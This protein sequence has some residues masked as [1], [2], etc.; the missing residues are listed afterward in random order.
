MQLGI[1]K[2]I[3]EE[4]KSFV[5]HQKKIMSEALIRQEA[6][7][8]TLTRS[9]K[10]RLEKNID[11]KGFGIVAEIKRASPYYGINVKKLF[12]AELA[13]IYQK[14]GASC[15]GVHTDQSFFKGKNQDLI[16]VRNSS[17]LPILRKDFIISKYQIYET[18]YLGADAILLTVALLEQAKL[19]EYS[20]LARE[21]G[22]DIVLEVNSTEDVDRAMKLPNKIICI[23][24][25]NLTSFKTDLKKSFELAKYIG[26]DE[27]KMLE[28]GI[29]NKEEIATLK[30]NHINSCILGGTLINSEN[31][32]ATIHKI[33]FS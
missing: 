28:G 4:K 32:A 33:F 6:E 14:A 20:L 30:Q 29:K 24:N 3:L 2:K 26:K 1:L 27:L 8:L 22:L 23:N 10:R 19:K 21:L 16:Q 17:S 31:P 7:K 18:A 5:T 12:P 13:L 25:R 9:F 11:L 15:I